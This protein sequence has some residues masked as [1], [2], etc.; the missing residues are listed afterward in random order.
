MVWSISFGRNAEVNFPD[1]T[2]ALLKVGQKSVIS[3][4]ASPPCHSV[5]EVWRQS[6]RSRVLKENQHSDGLMYFVYFLYFVLDNCVMVL[7][8][9][10]FYFLF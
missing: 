7:V 10:F 4:L 6:G 5:N 1:P 3:T 2:D 8:V 9:I